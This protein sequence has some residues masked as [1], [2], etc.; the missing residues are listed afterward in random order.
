[1]SPRGKRALVAAAAAVAAGFLGALV[2]WPALKRE[3]PPLVLMVPEDPD[4]AAW[5]EKIEA[6]YPPIPIRAFEDTT[7]VR[8]D[9]A[10]PLVAKLYVPLRTPDI[11]WQSQTN[12]RR[13]SN[14][15][16]RTP[17]PEHPGGS[18]I[19]ATNQD[20]LRMDAELDLE[21]RLFVVA[22]DSHMEG[23]CSNGESAAG[24]LAAAL[25]PTDPGLEVVNA[26]CGGYS[27]HQYLGTLEHLC[28]D[29]PGQLVDTAR[30]VPVEAL[31][32][33]IYGGND[34]SEVLRLAHYFH[35]SNR[36]AGWGRDNARVAPLRKSHPSVLGQ[37]VTS[38]L[39]FRNAPS[40]LQLA[41]GEC[42]DVAEEL[43]RHANRRGIRLV[44]CYLPSALSAERERHAAK[45]APVVEALEITPKELAAEDAHGDLLIQGLKDLGAEVIDLRPLLTDDEQH[46]WSRDLHLNTRGQAHVAA[47]LLD[48]F[49]SPSR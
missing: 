1:M 34:L 42:L 12:F 37:A 14:M 5:R 38:L 29:T 31:A 18:W 40:E 23:A 49:R 26:S 44:F 13:R 17:W 33:V 39:Y 32:V 43:E 11:V 28:G 47:A 15:H 25:E 30:P 19:L 36:P 21:K 46:F 10:E 24:L 4:F 9:L 45:L 41:L 22:G 16:R 2:L 48:W 8:Y 35:H 7:L 20:G 3:P 27:M 6:E